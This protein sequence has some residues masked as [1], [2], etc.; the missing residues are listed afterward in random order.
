MNTPKGCYARGGEM[1]LADITV[2]SC[3]IPADSD[4]AARR[5]VFIGRTAEL[6]TLNDVLEDVRGR[7]PRLVLIDGPPGMGKTALIQEF[8]R[9]A[10]APTVLH[11]S[12]EETETRLAFGVI[13]Q[14]VSQA[15]VPPMD[16]LSSIDDGA[17]THADPLVVGR[18]FLDLIGRV[19]QRSPVVLLIDDVQ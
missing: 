19:Q 15:C 5:R 6:A 4:V 2:S 12:G 9:I 14:F 8:A 3:H 13:G 10:R 18:A 11:A 7:N 16:D 1:D 17:G